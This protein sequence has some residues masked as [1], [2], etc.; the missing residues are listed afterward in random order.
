[1]GLIDI[2]IG[3]VI[4]L[5]GM[6]IVFQ[7]FS[8]FEGQKRTTTAANDAQEAGLMALGLIERDLRMGGYGFFSANL[9]ACSQLR[10][11][12]GA[13]NETLDPFMPAQIVDGATNGP[14]TLRVSYSTSPF[15]A[16]PSTLLQPFGGTVASLV[17]DNPAR[18]GGNTS[19]AYRVGDQI[20][21]GNA[22]STLPCT[23]LQV[24]GIDNALIGQGV[25]AIGVAP[26]ADAPHNPGAG[27]LTN[28]LPAGGYL[29]R[30]AAPTTITNFGAFRRVEY[31]VVPDAVRGGA[32][33]TLDLNPLPGVAAADVVL[34]D[35]V[36]TLQAQYGISAN[37]NDQSI[38]NWVNA[39]AAPW[40]TPGIAEVGRI[41]AIRVAV[42]A[43]SQLPE[44]DNVQTLDI[45]CVNGSGTNANGPCA[46]RDTAG[47]PAPI[48]DLTG[49][50]EWRRYRYRVYETI[51]PLR[52]VM[53]QSF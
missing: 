40:I 52:N 50:A 5:I 6:I 10:W 44:R 35:G 51:V 26:T 15:G 33:V 7:A 39:S 20:V 48:I 23:R 45:P 27:D 41:K 32:L 43:R 47:A 19:A 34:A 16:T 24:S 46:W 38:S 9:L 3:M 4:G 49:N 13:A 8:V 14:D 31:R 12:R 22:F 36:M 25:I 28:L 18:T 42:V 30:T 53:W 21:V 1:M 37:A 2:L 17:V 11:R 29:A